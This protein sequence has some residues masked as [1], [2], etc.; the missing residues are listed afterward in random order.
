[1]GYVKTIIAR[2]CRSISIDDRGLREEDASRG[3]KE[4]RRRRG[5][6]EG[7]GDER[8]R[9]GKATMAWADIRNSMILQRS[10]ASC[11]N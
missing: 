2:T 5:T 11:C 4:R 9:P 10:R 7:S 8:V 1:M 6:R 3:A